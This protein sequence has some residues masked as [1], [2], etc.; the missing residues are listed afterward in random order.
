MAFRR[1]GRAFGVVVG[2]GFMGVQA[3]SSA[4]YLEV[5]WEKIKVDVIKP[6]DA[7]SRL[8]DARSD[9]RKVVEQPD[10]NVRSQLPS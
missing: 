6:L 8:A 5:D 3:A 2:I 9:G 7:V 10:S 1:V 4:G